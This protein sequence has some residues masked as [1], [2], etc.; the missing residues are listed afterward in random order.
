MK[1]SLVELV[2]AIIRRIQERPDATPS[3]KGLRSWLARQ[4]F[5][6]H[7][8]DAAMKLMRPRFPDNAKQDGNPH[9]SVRLLSPQEEYKLSPEAR[10]ILLRLELYGMINP[11]EREMILDHLGHFEGEVGVDEL[12]YLVAWMVCGGRDIG[13]QQTLFDLF[14][15]KDKTLH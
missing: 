5:K 12:D 10:N 3:E 6:K 7:E 9:L 13:F 15:D 8:I 4:G 11:M 1:P 2:N 14:E